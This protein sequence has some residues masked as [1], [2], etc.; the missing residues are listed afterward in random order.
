MNVEPKATASPIGS[1]IYDLNPVTTQATTLKPYRSKTGTFLN[2]S[3]LGNFLLY[4]NS[5]M[6]D[7][8]ISHGCLIKGTKLIE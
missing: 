7:I 2:I 1:R 6:V 4:L 5:K 3:D 8:F